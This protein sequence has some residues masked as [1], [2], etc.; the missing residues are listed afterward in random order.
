[1]AIRISRRK[2]ARYYTASLTSGMDTQKLALQLAAYLVDSGRVKELKLIIDDIEYQLSLN[3]IVL[4]DV[5]SAH[6]LDELTKTAITDLVNKKTS[7]TKIQLREHIDSSILGGMRLKFP[8]VEL[9]TTI[10][11]RLKI[12]MTNYKK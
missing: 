3:G 9:D 10:A 5:T 2:L 6:S 12:L 8:G 1:M 7:A 4:V 11:R